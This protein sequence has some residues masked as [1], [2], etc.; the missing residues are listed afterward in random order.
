QLVTVN[1]DRQLVLGM[2]EANPGDMAGLAGVRQKHRPSRP[3][4]ASFGRRVIAASHEDRAGLWLLYE[5]RS[6][7]R[8]PLGAAWL[9][10]HSFTIGELDPRRQLVREADRAVGARAPRFGRRIEATGHRRAL[11][12]H[13]RRVRRGP[14]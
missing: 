9:E 11:A 10:G 1:T 3:K 13:W 5:R 8:Q 2:G 12:D 6:R 14:G 4:S 7:T